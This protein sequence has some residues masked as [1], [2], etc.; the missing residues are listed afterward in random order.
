MCPVF[1]PSD[2]DSLRDNLPIIGIRGSVPSSRKK[3]ARNMPP[4]SK[5]PPPLLFDVSAAVVLDVET[6]HDLGA[7]RDAS[8]TSATARTEFTTEPAAAHEID[9]RTDDPVPASASGGPTT[10]PAVGRRR[11]AAVGR[12]PRFRT[13][14]VV[15]VSA[16]A[17]F[18]SRRRRFCRAVGPVVG[19]ATRGEYFGL[20]TKSSRGYLRSESLLSSYQSRGTV[21]PSVS[22]LH[23]TGGGGPAAYGELIDGRRN[24]TGGKDICR[25]WDRQDTADGR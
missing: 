21:Q 17:A 7:N 6:C 22:I 12:G 13:R 19:R 11:G 5:S 16:A 15:V 24:C 3:A 20:E 25:L 9:G 18:A 1:I 14:R 8:R 23:A 10:S 4:L 2:I